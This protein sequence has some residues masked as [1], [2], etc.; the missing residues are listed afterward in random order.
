MKIK[1]ISKVYEKS[2]SVYRL[3]SKLLDWV[4]LKSISRNK[5][6]LPPYCL[7]RWE[8]GEGLSDRHL[9]LSQQYGKCKACEGN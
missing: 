6:L 3:Y 5:P 8:L 4:Y 9:H 7:D 1:T 2:I